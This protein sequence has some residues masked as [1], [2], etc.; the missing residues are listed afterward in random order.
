MFSEATMN[1][2]MVGLAE[3]LYMVLVSTAAAYIIGLPL[4]LALVISEESPRPV[5]RTIN[6]ALGLIVNLLRSVPFLIL[7]MALNPFTRMVV[8]TT[9]GPNAAAVALVVASAPFIARLVESS[10]KE[11]DKG[12]IEAAHSMGA[13][14]PQIITKVLLPEAR[15]SLLVGAAIA[16]TTILS[17]S[18]MAGIIGGG[19]LG[20]IAIRY[21]YYRYQFDVML[22]TMILL[23]ILVQVL[24]EIGMKLAKVLDKRIN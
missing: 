7:M 14:M 5:I 9:I 17:Y 24:Q 4:G 1:M 10:I 6:K 20:D 2:F 23:V 15:P 12:V 19:G 21:G 8:G 3:T 16:V 11:V 18:A 13:S 22:V